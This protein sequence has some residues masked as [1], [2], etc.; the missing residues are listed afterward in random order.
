[1]HMK[2]RNH[3]C[4]EPGR[5]SRQIFAES[6]NGGALGKAVTPSEQVTAMAPR[7][8]FAES[9][10]LPRARPTAKDR[11]ADGH[12]LPSA[13]LGKTAHFAESCCLPRCRPTAILSLADGRC[14][15]RAALGKRFLC[16]EPA[17]LLSAKISDL[18]KGRFSGSDCRTSSVKLFHKWPFGR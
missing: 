14:L 15:P 2:Y 12:F 7:Q 1:M 9:L 18:G 10:I 8:C 5:G 4:R 13:A 16:R 3:I 11:F 17:F 6:S